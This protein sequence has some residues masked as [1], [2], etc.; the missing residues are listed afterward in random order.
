[1]LSVALALLLG[2]IPRLDPR[3]RREPE[4]NERSNAAIG[5][6][7][8]ATTALVSFGALLIAAE[9][10]GHRVNSVRLGINLV[11]L[12]F[13]VLGNYIGT[14]RP[15]YSVGIRTPWTLESD[16]VWR[17]THRNC[18]RILVFG[19]LAFFALQLL[20]GQAYMLPCYFGFVAATGLWSV[21]YSYLRLRS[22]NPPAPP[23]GGHSG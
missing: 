10:L 15:N 16:D 5:A 1:V 2:W 22:A 14:V 20:V 19:T 8:L 23:H 12:F 3:L 7:R 13:V 18:G 9:A 21:I 17:A 6:I 4:A 11:L